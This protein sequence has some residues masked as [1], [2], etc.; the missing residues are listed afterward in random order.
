VFIAAHTSAGKT[1]TIEYAIG[2]VLLHKICAIYISPT[3]ALSNQQTTFFCE[4]F[5]NSNYFI[6]DHDVS[7]NL[8]ASYLVMAIKFLAFHVYV[9]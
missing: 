9:S 2:L 7:I 3:K 8:D 6:T 5:V 4:F 1:V